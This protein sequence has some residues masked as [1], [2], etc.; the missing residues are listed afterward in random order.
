MKSMKTG[1]IAALLVVVGLGLAVFG[2]AP[3]NPAA[4]AGLQLTG[5]IIAAL[6][7][8]Q[9]GQLVPHFEKMRDEA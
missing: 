2:F 3:N 7:I 4:R 1:A 5:V 9:C 8:Y 6:G